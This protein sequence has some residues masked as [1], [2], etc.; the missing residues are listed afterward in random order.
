MT[1]TFQTVGALTD[2]GRGFYTTVG[3]A[4]DKPMSKTTCTFCGQCLSVCPTGALTELSYVEKV[5]DAFRDGKHVF[6]Q[7]APAIR[8]ALG[9]AFDM[10]AGTPVTGKMV[11]ALRR[12]GFEKVFDT[13]FAADL[14]I[15]EEATEFLGRY[16]SGENL[17]ILTSCCPGWVNF[18]EHF[19]PELLNIPS[20]CK[21][22]HE[23]FAAITKTY[24]ADKLGLDPKDIVLVSIMPCVAKKYEAARAELAVDRKS[25]V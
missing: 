4:F 18:F 23:M 24:L 8:A 12:L 20:S 9:E 6:V 19:F 3:S 14:T 11:T 10:P 15:M 2:I 17:P 25:V 21:S 22:P 7:T 1:A 13:D 16:K 5:W